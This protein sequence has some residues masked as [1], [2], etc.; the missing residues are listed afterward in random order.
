MTP[1]L[2]IQ[3]YMKKGLTKIVFVVDRSGSM[4][5]VSKD[6][7]G[8]FNRYIKT[9]KENKV[10]ECSVTFVQ[11]DTSYDVVYK[12][13]SVENVQD[14]TDET[15]VPRGSTALYDAVGK[16]VTDVGIELNLLTEDE[17]PEK[18]LV[19]IL[20]D[21]EEN[22]SRKFTSEQVK[23]LVK[24]QTD[25]YKWEF[26]YI[27]ANQD[28]WAVGNTLGISASNITSYVS[29]GRNTKASNDIL[30]DKLSAK[31]VSFRSA[32]KGSMAYTSD[33]VNEQE[34]LVKSNT[35]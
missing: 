21:G 11:F 4:A 3:K 28:V 23:E 9:Q 5:S 6:M 14:L 25:V 19:V 8:G 22:A 15:F 29:S 16:A 30:W 33:E 24:H 12:N 34:S 26:V 7:I 32:T 35:P 27:G 31:T 2:E 13:I 10:G 20:T 17:R 18:V 1:R